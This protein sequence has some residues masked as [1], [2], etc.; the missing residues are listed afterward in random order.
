[1]AL[2][3]RKEKPVAKDGPGNGYEVSAPV[4][5]FDE[6]LTLEDMRYWATSL[7]GLWHESADESD[8][9]DDQ[10]QYEEDLYFQRFSI[11]SPQGKYIVKTG[12]AP[13]DADAAIDS[14][15][16]T[17]IQVRVR[18]ARNR[19]NHK[20][21]AEKLAKFG[22]G[23]L[24]YWRQKKDIFRL[25]ASDQVIR[26]VGVMRVMF[27]TRLWP[28]I[29]N[30]LSGTK[31]DDWEWKKRGKFPV[32]AEVRNPRSTRWRQTDGGDMLAVV[33]KYRTT[34]AEAK[35]ALGEYNKAYGYMLGRM[36]NE[37]VT[38]T[39]VF[40]GRYRSVFLDNDPVIDGSGIEEHG[41]RR[42][43][44]VIIPFR[45][46][47]FDHPAQR[48][49]GML[50]NAAGLYEIESQVLTMHV[51]QL[52][53]NSWRTW[54]GHTADGRKI[55]IVPG[56]FIPIDKERNE[57]IEMLAGEP[58]PPE[59][60]QTASIIG[61]YIQRNGI[62]QGPNTQE[63]TR[64]AQQVWAIQSVR[65]IKVEPGK[66]DF[67]RAIEQMLTL[68]AE[69]ICDWLPDE[70]IT[71][72]VPGRDE[73]GKPIGEITI[74]AAEIEGYEESFNVTFGRRLDPA[75]LEQAKAVMTLAQNMW[76]PRRVSWELSG[77]TD[78]PEEWEDELYLQQVNDLDFMK[79]VGG[80]EATVAMY[81]ERS[82]QAQYYRQRM[83]TPPPGKSGQPSGPAGGL[84]GQPPSPMQPT[85]LPPGPSPAA[86]PAPGAPGP[87]GRPG[88]SAPSNVPQGGM[89]G[90]MTPGI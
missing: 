58:V 13:A 24:S 56:E 80:W 12:S 18:P 71:L 6:R 64:S 33:E 27:D 2:V 66:Q 3:V 21:R 39:D 90:Q 1:M 16:P 86:R 75:L 8:A 46:L 48:Y 15:T 83:Q 53:W 57:Y 63:G 47:H 37:Q 54:V 50:S 51:W 55:S 35:I 77:L 49:R 25:S 61:S 74:S 82:W 5:E 81:G 20:R 38:I 40:V 59:L 62:A 10:Q 73:A 69:I 34:I 68:M 44:Y 11:D 60:L 36:P 87:A 76:M 29:P 65:Q 79:E 67:Q 17:D 9:L 88:S 32:I 89:P 78:S 31:K 14:I 28:P 41:Y 84:V 22:R 19:D 42:P 30:N 72:P 70:K 43:P 4:M 7:D 26:R 23:V 85:A 45:E 52:A